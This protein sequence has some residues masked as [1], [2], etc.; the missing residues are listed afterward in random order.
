MY[1]RYILLETGE[2]DAAQRPLFRPALLIKPWILFWNGLCYP[3][4][5]DFDFSKITWQIICSQMPA[6]DAIEKIAHHIVEWNTN[7]NSLENVSHIKFLDELLS[8]LLLAPQRKEQSS[9]SKLLQ[10]LTN[11]N[12]SALSYQPSTDLRSILKLNDEYIF[13]NHKELDEFVHLLAMQASKFNIDLMHEYD[14]AEV[15]RMFDMVFWHQ[16]EESSTCPFQKCK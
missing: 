16:N 9:F 2:K 15:L 11:A 5:A 7:S 1:I 4:T 8:C 10:S 3:Y 6:K 12:S 14:D 13:D